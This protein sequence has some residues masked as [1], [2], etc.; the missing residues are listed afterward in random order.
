MPTSPS[1]ASDLLTSGQSGYR[2]SLGQA[3]IAADEPIMMS[4]E[5]PVYSDASAFIS[6]RASNEELSDNELRH[7]AP[8]PGERQ[9]LRRCMD[10]FPNKVKPRH[11]LASEA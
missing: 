7:P 1:N 5:P 6:A 2:K 3:A 11:F 10:Y 8:E 4:D 9:W